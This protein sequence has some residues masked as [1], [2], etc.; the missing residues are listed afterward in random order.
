MADNVAMSPDELKQQIR[1]I[2]V[3]KRGDQRAPHKPLL[4]LYALGRCLNDGERL[5]PYGEVDRELRPLLMEFGPERK[6]CHTEY[7]FQRLANDGIWELQ[8]HLLAEADRAGIPIVSNTDEERV[9]RAIMRIIT[10]RLSH[11][12]EG[13][14]KSVF[15]ATRG[16]GKRATGGPA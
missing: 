6:S 16:G 1:Q 12:F 5:L 10:D 9:F 3:W 11:T 13:N 2:T 14:V 4:L 15:H 8:K 7:P